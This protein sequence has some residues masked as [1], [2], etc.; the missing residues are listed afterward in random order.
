VIPYYEEFPI[1]IN[2]IALCLGDN[3]DGESAA[4][5]SFVQTSSKQNPTSCSM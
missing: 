1:K 5:S 2:Y 4:N 3:P